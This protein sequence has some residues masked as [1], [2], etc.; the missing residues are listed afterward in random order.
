MPSFTHRVSALSLLFQLVE[1]GDGVVEARFYQSLYRLLRTAPHIMPSTERLVLFFSLLY[2]AL[3][4]ETKFE[5]QI[6]FVHRLLQVSRAV[7]CTGYVSMASF[8][9]PCQDR[10]T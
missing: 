4:W 7:G 5:C 8:G 3:V 10:T 2:K 9:S 6:S 1:R